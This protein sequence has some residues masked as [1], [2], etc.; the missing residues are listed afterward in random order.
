M[1]GRTSRIP[2][3]YPRNRPFPPSRVRSVSP[4]ASRV[5][6]TENL[7]IAG[8]RWWP[9]RS[10]HGIVH[11]GGVRFPITGPIR[12]TMT[13]RRAV[14]LCELVR[15]RVAVPAHYEGWAHFKDGQAAVERELARA[16]EDVRRRVRWLPIGEPVD[17]G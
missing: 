9:G 8:H 12:Y 14:Q 17:L 16:P 13:A 5:D 4:A 2:F 15:P 6:L 10:G 3:A 11:V 1:G 7:L